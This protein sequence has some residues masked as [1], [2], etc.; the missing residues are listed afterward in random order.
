MSIS[1]SRTMVLTCCLFVSGSWYKN[2]LVTGK[3]SQKSLP[4]DENLNQLM[5]SER[6]VR[7]SSNMASTFS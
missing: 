2:L 6:S 5:E 3:G 7:C 4:H 1:S